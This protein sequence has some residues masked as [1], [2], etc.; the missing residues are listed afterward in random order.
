[1][2]LK[3]LCDTFLK[4]FSLA[5]F[6]KN[7]VSNHGTPFGLLWPHGQPLMMLGDERHAIFSPRAK[8]GVCADYCGGPPCMQSAVLSALSVV[9]SIVAHEQGRPLADEGGTISASTQ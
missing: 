7:L 3:L 8:V 5:R 2:G 6:A 9:D 1:M 4:F